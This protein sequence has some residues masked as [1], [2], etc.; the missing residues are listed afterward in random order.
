MVGESLV[1]ELF[2]PHPQINANLILWLVYAVLCG[3]FDVLL[4]PPHS[5]NTLMVLSLVTK[6]YRSALLVL[7]VRKR[8]V[9]GKVLS[10]HFCLRVLMATVYSSAT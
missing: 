3:S 9:H 8:H 5:F 1:F 4:C 6:V 10:H 2:W 7:E